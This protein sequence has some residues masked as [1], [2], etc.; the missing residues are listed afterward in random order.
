MNNLG[1]Y[2]ES[3]T[4]VDIRDE[5]V[6]GPRRFQ[7][8]DTPGE[9]LRPLRHS[10]IVSTQEH[11]R[12]R[13]GRCLLTLQRPISAPMRCISG[14]HAPKAP[15]DRA[16]LARAFMAKPFVEERSVIERRIPKLRAVH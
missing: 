16:A 1:S 11:R 3:S 15:A 9:A 4:G 13:V 12:D 5:Q 8:P 10:H 7:D 2:A 6:H 14:L